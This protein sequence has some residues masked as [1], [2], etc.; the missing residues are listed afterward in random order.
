M[1]PGDASGGDSPPIISV[2]SA[3]ALFCYPL[4]PYKAILAQQWPAR[5]KGA[6]CSSGCANVER[7][8]RGGSGERR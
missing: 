4:K 5:Q 1:M 6:E 3:S 8:D 2:L 7:D